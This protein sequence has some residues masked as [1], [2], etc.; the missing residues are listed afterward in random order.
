MEDQTRRRL[1][2]RRSKKLDWKK[3][4]AAQNSNKSANGKSYGV[5]PITDIQDTFKCARMAACTPVC[6]WV[7]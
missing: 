5:A 2:A 7:T 1:S 6:L 3:P 4:P